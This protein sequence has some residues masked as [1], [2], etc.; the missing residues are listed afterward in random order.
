MRSIPIFLAMLLAACSTSPRQDAKTAISTIMKA[1]E[2]AWNAGDIEAFMEPYQHS[3]SL[4]FIGSRGLSYGWQKVLDNYKTSYPTQGAMCTLRFE[5]KMFRPLG[6]EN[7]WVA[8]AWTLFRE[9]DTLSGHYTLVWA[10][11]NGKWVI[12]SDHSS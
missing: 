3:D 11:Q 9:A 7:Y 8:G 2:D 4:V 6:S 5:N 1:Q 10:L 12:I